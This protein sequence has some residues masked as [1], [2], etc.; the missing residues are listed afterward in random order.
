MADQRNVTAVD[1]RSQGIPFI[2]DRLRRLDDQRQGK[3]LA[4]PKRT[5]AMRPGMNVTTRMQPNP[6][7]AQ[8]KI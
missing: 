5:T 7:R 1:D 6:R 3:P 2:S 4:E 8:R